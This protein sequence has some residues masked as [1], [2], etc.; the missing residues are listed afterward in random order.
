MKKFPGFPKEP[1]TIVNGVSYKGNPEGVIRDLVKQI[2]ELREKKQNY[3]CVIPWKLLTD[4]NISSTAKL[5]YGEISALANREG[6]CWATNKHFAETFGI[7]NSTTIS[8]LIH[9]LEAVNYIYVEIKEGYKRRIWLYPP[10][11]KEGGV[12]KKNKGDYEKS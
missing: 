7:K 6:Y 9:K 1:A 10:V 11:L 12:M 3:Y 2:Q 5:L 8:A 4:K